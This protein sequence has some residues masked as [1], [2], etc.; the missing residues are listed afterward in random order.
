MIKRY[1]GV[2]LFDLLI[3]FGATV[4]LAVVAGSI[5]S[6]E[7]EIG[8]GL[9]IAASFGLLAWRRAR[10][11]AGQRQDTP[12][13]ESL[14]RVADLEDRVAELERGQARMLEL[15]ERMDFNERLLARQRDEARLAPGE[16]AR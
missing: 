6:P 2:D 4:A 16:Q 10:G 7:E 11:L 5:T 13:E 8:V 3:Q 9:V 1:L 14:Q 12:A 15:E